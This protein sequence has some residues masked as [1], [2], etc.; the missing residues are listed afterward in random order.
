MMFEEEKEECH[1]CGH[2]PPGPHKEIKQ[3]TI[4]TDIVEKKVKLLALLEAG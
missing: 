3:N 4:I 1:T 2:H